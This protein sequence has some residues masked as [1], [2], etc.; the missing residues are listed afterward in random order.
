MKNE[1]TVLSWKPEDMVEVT[2]KNPDDFTKICSTLKRIGVA[3]KDRRLI[4][5]C[6]ILHKK[7]KY[8][9]V[10]FKEMFNLDGKTNTFTESD[11]QKRNSIVKL[12]QDWD[13]C[14]V[15]NSE[16]IKNQRPVNQ[17]NFKIASYQEIQDGGWLLESK[18]T[19]ASERKRKSQSRRAA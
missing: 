12:L 13:L 6:H 15:V 10:H 11:L 4:Q 7:G 3:T 5:S 18:Y 1:E 9:I 2:L 19:F 17:L 16:A 8:Y 14:K